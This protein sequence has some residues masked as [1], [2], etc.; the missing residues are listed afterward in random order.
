MRVL[1]LVRI[2][3]VR[4]SLAPRSCRGNP[5]KGSYGA[6]FVSANIVTASI[7]ASRLIGFSTWS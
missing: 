7:N 3:Q 4:N 1:M 2:A 6:R 5:A